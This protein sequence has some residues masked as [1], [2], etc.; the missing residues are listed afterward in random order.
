MRPAWSQAFTPDA[1]R[2]ADN[3]PVLED[4]TPEWAWGGTSGK[5]VK[6]AIV[7]SGVDATKIGDF[8]TRIVAS[9]NFSSLSPDAYGDDQDHG[10]MVAGI[11]GGLE[12]GL[13]RR[14]AERADRRRPHHGR[15]G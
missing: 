1:L 5:G 12:P 3:L 13:P 7:D 15:Q 6:V 11:R 14:R 2:Y 8:G 9:V 4:I 10:T